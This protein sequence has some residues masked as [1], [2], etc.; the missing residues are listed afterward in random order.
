MLLETPD[1][2][3]CLDDTELSPWDAV[4]I[5]HNI[6]P[7]I[8]TGY[9]VAILGKVPSFFDLVQTTKYAIARGDI[10]AVQTKETPYRRYWA[11]EDAEYE[12]QS[13]DVGRCGDLFDFDLHIRG[14]ET[15]IRRLHSGEPWRECFEGLDEGEYEIYAGAPNYF[16]FNFVVHLHKKLRLH[17][18]IYLRH[19]A[20][21]MHY[22]GPDGAFKVNTE[23]PD[24]TV[25]LRDVCQF[26]TSN[27][28]LENRLPYRLDQAFGEVGPR[29]SPRKPNREQPDTDQ[30]VD[31][32]APADP[33]ENVDAKWYMSS[34]D[35]V[36]HLST[37]DDSG[38]KEVE[39]QPGKLNHH[40]IALLCSAWPEPISLAVLAQSVYTNDMA[41]LAKAL[42]DDDKEV[43]RLK[44][45]R[46]F[47]KVFS[48]VGDTRKKL[49]KAGINQNIISPPVRRAAAWDKSKIYLCVR[50]LSRG[51]S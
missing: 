50:K 6:A 4:L 41:A 47:N 43:L 40:L 27:G 35:G 30:F 44:T 33:I 36:I 28:L 32:P 17:L 18:E 11:P 13:I 37:C 45:Q 19:E 24:Y 38:H 12:P 20:S 42:Q 21:T 1:W 25:D 7:R 14:L 46:F 22:V 48:L 2:N 51:N 8:G 5:L 9:M 49:K 16:Y 39:F 29:K 26:F 3:R 23:W 10:P 31:K 15:Q 34:S